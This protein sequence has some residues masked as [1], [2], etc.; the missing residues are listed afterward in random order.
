MSAELDLLMSLFWILDC[1]LTKISRFR[2]LEETF[3][4]VEFCLSRINPGGLPGFPV[5]E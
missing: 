1:M 5:A 3:V 4:F 2:R